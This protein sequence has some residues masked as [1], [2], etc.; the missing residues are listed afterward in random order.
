MQ[1]FYVSLPSNVS[2]PGNTS[3][4]YTTILPK[5]VNL[6][7]GKHKVAV[8]D[9]VFP[10]T[11]VNRPLDSDFTVF[12]RDGTWENIILP[13][14][15]YNSI[16]HVVDTLNS[17]IGAPKK[18][19]RK[20]QA[21]SDPTSKDDGKRFED[22]ID[23]A[24]EGI[25]LSP[26]KSFAAIV[27]EMLETEHQENKVAK[28]AADFEEENQKAI[29]KALKEKAQLA[30]KEEKK[31]KEAEERERTEAERLEQKRK[32]EERRKAAQEK[33]DK[34]KKAADELIAR[35]KANEKAAEKAKERASNNVTV[36][37]DKADSVKKAAATATA[38]AQNDPDNP[39]AQEKAEKMQKLEKTA[40]EP[41][42]AYET[43]NYETYNAV[44]YRA[45]AAAAAY[46]TFNYRAAAAK[47]AIYQTAASYCS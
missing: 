29:A 19:R 13:A 40:A 34:D 5:E 14:G 41:A 18:K 32:D 17:I 7:K 33:A 37:T 42:A 23:A 24:L 4:R 26:P 3:S 45:A 27:D 30:E 22:V 2:Y 47:T 8:T 11:F 15:Q 6:R 9:V 1:D 46:E 36:Q 10:N 44:F 43:S 39:K 12:Y 38:K 25:D 21:P 16:E 28:A 35:A 31:R 20:R